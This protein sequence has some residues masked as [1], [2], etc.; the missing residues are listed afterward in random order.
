MIDTLMT[1]GSSAFV[2]VCGS[3]SPRLAPA[4]CG[5]KTLLGCG[6]AAALAVCLLP[7]SIDTARAQTVCVGPM[8]AVCNKPRP[9]IICC[10]SPLG[11][12][13]EPDIN[14]RGGGTR[15]LAP[16]RQ[17]GSARI[18]P[19]VINPAPVFDP[20]TQA[21][22]QPL[23]CPR[24]F[25]RIGQTFYGGTRC[26]PMGQ[27]RVTAVAPPRQPPRPARTSAQES[28]LERT[29]SVQSYPSATARPPLSEPP[30][31][32]M[33]QGHSQAQ[34]Q[35]RAKNNLRDIWDALSLNLGT[36]WPVVGGAAAFVGG[37]IASKV[38]YLL[39]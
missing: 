7:V 4:R 19:P 33:N 25:V 32:E 10:Q 3:L 31:P 27:P 16:R 22:I 18:A 35:D 37:F 20:R 5:W 9:G 14:Y 6:L 21:Q 39:L 38:W 13:C 1:I 24:G 2:V 34:D 26:A 11:Y 30:P 36:T 29:P 28:Q 17:P 23:N 12:T 8:C 15:R